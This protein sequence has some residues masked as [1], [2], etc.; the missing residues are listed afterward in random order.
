MT[1]PV[2]QCVRKSLSDLLFVIMQ[3]RNSREH[4]YTTFKCTCKQNTCVIPTKVS[5]TYIHLR[6]H[7]RSSGLLEISLPYKVHSPTV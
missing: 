5:V 4:L 3:S 6:A 7:K 1:P 2:H